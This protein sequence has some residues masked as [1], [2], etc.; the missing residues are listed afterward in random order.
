[1]DKKLTIL[2]ALA[3]ATALLAPAAMAA[4][5]AVPAGIAAAHKLYLANC[6]QCHGKDLEG[7]AGPNLA[8]AEWLHGAPSKAKLV[9]LIGKGVPEKGMPAWSNQ[10]SANQIS[11]LADY[12]LP[13]NAAA[14]KAAAG[15]A[16]PVA[17]AAPAGSAPAAAAVA[18]AARPAAQAPAGLAGLKLPK[19]FQIAVYADKVESARE[20]AVTASGLVFVGSRKAGKVYAL[21]DADRDGVAE[22]VVTVAEG[23]N[24]P[25]GVALLDGALYVG[26]ISR[27]LKFD[28]I[29]QTYAGKPAYKVIKD[30]LPSDTWHGEK[31]IKAGPDGKLYIPI[32]APCNVC[33]K[34]EDAYAKI[35]RMNPDGSNWEL[36]ARGV[37]NTVGFTWHPVT[38]EMWFTDNGRD[39][40]GDNMP[41]C[42]LNVAPKA[43]MHFGFPYCHAGVLPDP[44][45]GKGKSC[46]AYTAPVAQLGPHVAPLGLAFY[47]GTQ[48]P[49]QYRNQL[50]VAEHGSWNRANKIGYQVRLITLY[51]NKLVSD[52]AFI[53]G[54]L[55]DEQVSGRP[56]DIAVMPDGSILVSDDH[57]HKVYRVSY[58]P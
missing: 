38:K 15:G 9:R 26:E 18:G 13:A 55:Q 2:S 35:W 27:I 49:A 22:K 47:T 48:F 21:V 53:D 45:F 39:E 32:G 42:E 58:R 17:V 41:S 24:K 43:G 46:D 4:A 8:D 29:E 20:L 50:L 16:A 54:F 5:P 23:L 52:T 12:L 3:C 28:N 14:R 40:L 37:R 11:Q 51:G 30:D 33:D 25:N 56:V 36:F 19:G 31:Y 34:E 6:A 10:L 44:Q 1:M 57:A 7:A